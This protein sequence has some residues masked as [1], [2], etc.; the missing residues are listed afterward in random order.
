MGR[1]IQTMES[2]FGHGDIRRH[3]AAHI[4]GTGDRTMPTEAVLVDRKVRARVNHGR[5]IVDCPDPDCGGAELVSPEE[6]VFFCCECRNRRARH[7]LLPVVFPKPG[8]RADIETYLRARPNEANQNWK[9]G[10]TVVQLRDE[11]RAE[12]ITLLPEDR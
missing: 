10:E 8:V 5:W 1:H 3:A 2:R 11:N 9:P 4:S 6:R 12:G 7:A